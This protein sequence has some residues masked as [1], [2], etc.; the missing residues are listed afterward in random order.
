MGQENDFDLPFNTV[1]VWHFNQLSPA[2]PAERLAAVLSPRESQRIDRLKQPQH[3]RRY[4]E[5]Q[6]K[7]RVILGRYLGC[8]AQ[9]IEFEYGRHGKPFLAGRELTFNL[10]HSGDRGLLAVARRLNLGI[11]LECWHELHNRDRLVERYFS[12][13]EKKIW[14]TIPDTKRQD[15]FFRLWTCKESFMKATGRG[16]GLGLGRCAFDF[17][18]PP[19]LLQCPPEYGIPD[20]WSVRTIDVE[21]GA[22]AALVVQGHDYDHGR[23]R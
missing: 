9:A 10:T 2:L 3:K 11:D 22:S 20:D 14:Q 5:A 16:L 17:S 19:E 8:P 1:H 6:A 15:A 18:E 7:L 23:T 21:A 12:E 13:I 4:L